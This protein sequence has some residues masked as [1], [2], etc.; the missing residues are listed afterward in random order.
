M[1]EEPPALTIIASAP[2]PTEAQIKAF[3][4]AE[5]AQVCDA[6]GG[7]A[8]MATEIGPL[9][10]G[11]DLP[12][13]IFGAVAVADNR[14]GDLL[15][16]LAA[17][18]HIFPGD[19]LVH[20]AHGHQGCATVGDQVSGMLRNAGAAGLVT[21]GPVR[22]YEGI[23]TTGLPIWCTGLNPNSPSTNGPGI[24]GG[25]A[26]VGGRRVC[27]GDIIVADMTGVAVVPHDRID[28]VIGKLA[29]VKRLEAELAVRVKDGFRT[30]LDTPQMVK[31]G[32]AVVVY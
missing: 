30:P 11:R 15:A 18:E 26:I 10:F 27:T 23:V 28:E 7:T 1:I 24:V 6:L 29:E 16:T 20:A 8:A 12:S 17:V 4:D 22:D 9:G 25:C 32:K 21:D 3:E 14:P 5:S 13:R 2:R 31:D 19:I